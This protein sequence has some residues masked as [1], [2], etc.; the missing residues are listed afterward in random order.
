MGQQPKKN[1][2]TVAATGLNKIAVGAVEI[3]RFIGTIMALTSERVFGT[4]VAM[5]LSID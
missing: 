1:D 3:M 2:R 5:S 4:V